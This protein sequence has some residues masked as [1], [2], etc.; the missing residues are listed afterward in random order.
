MIRSKLRN[1]YFQRKIKKI[2]SKGKRPPDYRLNRNSGCR[3][4]RKIKDQHLQSA[5]P[6]ILKPVRDH[7]GVRGEKKKFSHTR[8]QE[9]YL[10]KNFSQK[11]PQRQ[12][13]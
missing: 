1:Y 10:T 11:N 8:T 2:T 12:I 3:K 6:R 13:N 5:E 4:I 7:L 9:I